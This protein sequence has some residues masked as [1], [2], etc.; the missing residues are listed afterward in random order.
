MNEREI[1]LEC[2]KLVHRPGL[3]T[4]ASVNEAKLLTEFVLGTQPETAPASKEDKA[5]EPSK[6]APG[7]K[8]G[9]ADLLS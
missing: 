9:N 2:L 7:K 4:A 5:Q 6:K 8:S 3:P 1:R